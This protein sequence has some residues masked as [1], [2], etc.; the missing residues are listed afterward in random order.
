MSFSVIVHRLAVQDLSEA[1][2]WY[3]KRRQGLGLEFLSTVDRTFQ[4]IGEQPLQ[5]PLVYRQLRRAALQRFPYLIYF[6]ADS[7]RVVVVACLHSK[8]NP[9]IVRTRIP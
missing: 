9:Q 3:E 2:D 8:R 7:D 6:R 4:K 1:R 5:Y